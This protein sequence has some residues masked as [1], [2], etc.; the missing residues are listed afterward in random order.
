M[1]KDQ[2]EIELK[3]LE[4]EKLKI[5]EGI[6][7]TILIMILTVGAGIGT[8]ANFIEVPKLWYKGV[9]IGLILIF[10]IFSLLFLYLLFSIRKKLK[11]L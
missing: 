11:E 5:K 1:D 8:L 2:K 6:A 9:F 10:I 4:I 3:K 7:R